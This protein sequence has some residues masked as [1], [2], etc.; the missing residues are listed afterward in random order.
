ME[1]IFYNKKMSILF[2]AAAMLLIILVCMLLTT[3]TQNSAMKQRAEE[4]N[5]L[6][7]DENAN[8]QRLEELLQYYQSNEYFSR[9]AEQNGYVS[10]KAIQWLSE[11]EK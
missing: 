1:H 9:W 10:N 6:V 3:L 2:V 11:N 5:A 4:L 8:K 7:E